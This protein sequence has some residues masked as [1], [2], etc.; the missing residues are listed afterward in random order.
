MEAGKRAEVWAKN[1]KIT[2]GRYPTVEEYLQMKYKLFKALCKQH[3][4]SWRIYYEGISGDVENDQSNTP[5]TNYLFYLRNHTC[6]SLHNR[7]IEKKRY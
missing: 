3:I 5:I 6:N 2:T 4:I 7:E 1:K